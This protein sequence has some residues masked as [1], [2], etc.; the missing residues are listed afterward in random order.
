MDA[1][2]AMGDMYSVIVTTYMRV[3]V[4]SLHCDCHVCACLLVALN[5]CRSPLERYPSSKLLDKKHDKANTLY[6]YVFV[7]PLNFDDALKV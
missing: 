3:S 2:A 1:A 6:V 7:S 4:L 5:V